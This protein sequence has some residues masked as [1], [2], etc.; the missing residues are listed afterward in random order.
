MN[1]EAIKNPRDRE[2]SLQG[3]IKRRGERSGEEPTARPQMKANDE[4]DKRT[5]HLRPD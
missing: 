2:K 3:I 1:Q 5:V 4:E